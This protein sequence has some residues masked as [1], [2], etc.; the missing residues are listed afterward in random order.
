MKR[1]TKQLEPDL[2]LLAVDLGYSAR[3][4]SCG[5]AWSGGAVVQSLE[6]GEC[7]EAVAQQLSNVGRHTL[8]LEAVLSTYHAIQGNPMIR[9][10]FEKGRGWYHGPGVTTF[11]AALRFVCELDR[12]LP[13]DLRPIP[14]VEGFLSYKPVRTAHSEDAL[15][16]LVEFDQAECFEAL[17]E[18]EPICDLLDGV[19][20]IRRYNKPA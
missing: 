18:S 11:A 16:L 9:G 2:P 4:K 7:I 17:A 19:P 8:I 20:Q 5:V 12:V 3:S 15:R 1:Y 13:N 10:E 6:F 14:L